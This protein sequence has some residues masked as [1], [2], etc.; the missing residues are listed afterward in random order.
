MKLL[1]SVFQSFNRSRN[2]LGKIRNFE[3]SH[4]TR[5][6]QEFGRIRNIITG[7]SLCSRRGMTEISASE[8]FQTSGSVTT[9]QQFSFVSQANQS[10]V[11]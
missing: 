10:Y 9:K 8:F 3:N 2:T 11:G 7:V 1:Y 6:M 5:A 4:N